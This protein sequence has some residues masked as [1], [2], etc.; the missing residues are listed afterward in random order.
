MRFSGPV[1]SR[2]VDPLLCPK[3]MLLVGHL[4]SSFFS[5]QSKKVLLEKQA[6]VATAAL[7]TPVPDLSF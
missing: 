1:P 4:V 7:E 6:P 5:Q 2:G 3:F